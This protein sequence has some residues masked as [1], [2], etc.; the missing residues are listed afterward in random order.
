MDE[1]VL[2]RMLCEGKMTA[3]DVLQKTA[4]DRVDGVMEILL[5]HLPYDDVRRALYER[6][7]SAPLADFDAL[8][9]A[10]FKHCEHAA[11]IARARKRSVSP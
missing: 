2:E 4:A 5:R 6:I 7:R 9:M 1:Q 8:R 11:S 10:Y 3:E